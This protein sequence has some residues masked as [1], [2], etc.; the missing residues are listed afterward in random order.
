MTIDELHTEMTAEFKAVRT[1]M[2]GEFTAVRA[3]FTAVR[4]E[5]KT[6]GETLDARIKAEGETTRRHFDIVA[7]Q[8]KEF[9]KGLADG[10]SQNT[11][12]LDDHE[13]RISAIETRGA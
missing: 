11:E 12:R 9:T 5:M 3:E 8:F 2:S 4:A 6:L 7:E 13:R 10:T 1:E